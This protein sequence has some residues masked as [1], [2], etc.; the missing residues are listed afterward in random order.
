MPTLKTKGAEIFHQS[1]GKGQIVLFSH[2]YIATGEMWCEQLKEPPGGYC[3]V[4]WDLRGHGR[5]S[6]PK[7]PALYSEP[8]TLDDM[9]ALLDY[10]EAERAVLVGHS[11]GGYMSLAFR[12]R[13]PE[14]V[15]GL[16]LVSSGPGYRSDEVRNNWNRI[17]ERQAKRIETNGLQALSKYTELDVS[18]HR[19]P[20]GLIHAARGM[21]TQRDDKV[22][23]ALAGIDI[24]TLVVVGEH[25]QHYRGAAAYMAAKITTAT[26]FEI[27][28]A[29]HM[30]NATDP[31]GFNRALHEFLKKC[32]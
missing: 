23:N 30:S 16:V 8:A 6:S 11:L 21:L 25:D 13:H 17:A 32:S 28:G 31:V 3:F 24:P 18:L 19:A 12:M 5:S 10:Y 29:G 27:P 2:G 9:A 4:S 20:M 1:R 22:I 26:H 7:D 14:R 15:R